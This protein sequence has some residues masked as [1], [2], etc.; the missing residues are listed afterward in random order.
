MRGNFSI[1]CAGALAT[2]AVA[3]TAC[4]GDAG[5]ATRPTVTPAATP[6]KEQVIDRVRNAVAQ[7]TGKSEFGGTQSGTLTII[8]AE[9]GLA[10][11]N[12]HVVNEMTQ[13]RANFG[14][15][16]TSPVVVLGTNACAD[17]ALVKIKNVPEGTLSMPFADPA[18]IKPG[19]EA[20]TAGFPPSSPT[21]SNAF[22]TITSGSITAEAVRNADLGSALNRQ[23]LMVQTDA[24]INPGNSGGPLFNNRGQVIGINT[25]SLTSQDSTYLAI[26]QSIVREALP[27][28]MAG[29]KGTGLGLTPVRTLN[30]GSLLREIYASEG[31]S[32]RWARAAGGVVRKEG[33]LLVT[34]VE[35]NSPADRANLKVGMWIT[36]MNGVKVQSVTGACRTEE[37]LGPKDALKIDGWHLFSGSLA[38][39]YTKALSRRI[40][41]VG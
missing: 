40:K 28:L 29:K 21:G 5:P 19:A 41:N 30:I 11:T 14:T 35:P 27:D 23:K 12:A 26:D 13:T 1:P 39:S 15:K 9:K 4:G 16:G 37:S 10:I 32:A 18:S 38:S 25:Y 36:E 31:V 17:L 3:V 33:G 22:V 6:T 34:H 7:I 8:N 20:M 2:L 24:A